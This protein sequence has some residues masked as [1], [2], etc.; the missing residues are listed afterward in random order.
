MHLV[1]SI[2]SGHMLFETKD[3]RIKGIEKK[4]FDMEKHVEQNLQRMNETIVT[5]REIIIQLQRE[6]T[7][8]R[9]ERDFLVER[10]KKMLRRVPVPDLAK[11]VSEKLV[12]PA[13]VKIKENADFVR[14]LA[15]EGFVE[16]KEPPDRTTPQAPRT[17][18]KKQQYKNPAKEIKQ[19]LDAEKPNY[20]K[21]IDALF[22]IISKSG[23]IRSDY[24]ARKLNVH[25]VQIEEWAKILEDHELITIKKHFGKLELAK[26]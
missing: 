4:I 1:N 16:I 23:N 24:A 3:E 2:S 17:K 13:A 20:G 9:G 12:K 22:E 6:N 11:E 10:H 18:E 7:R 21:T 15:K 26:I 25:E 5:L 19:Q 8:L 14:L